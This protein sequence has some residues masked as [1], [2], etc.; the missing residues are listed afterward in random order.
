M[1][2]VGVAFVAGPALE[3]LGALLAGPLQL[4]ARPLS[5]PE[6]G[7]TGSA[8]RAGRNELWLLAGA[9]DAPLATLYAGRAP[10]LGMA[11]RAPAASA[12]AG[13]V[14]PTLAALGPISLV[15]PAETFGALVGVFPGERPS[16][17]PRHDI[18]Q[19]IDHV[20]VSSTDSAATAARFA[21]LFDVPV[22]R[23][24]ARP[25]TNNHLEFMKPGEVVVEF[26]GPPEP[27]PEPVRAWVWG[28][29]LTVWDMVR[30]VNAIRAAGW[31]TTDPRPAVQPGARIAA[32]KGGTDG[33]P[34]ALIQYNA[35]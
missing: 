20:V 10:A 6:A 23:T 4:P 14:H 31:E 11:W 33:V 16:E 35:L 5:F 34:F 30:T 13:K 12:W 8:F 9:D 26:G 7:A 2:D 24:M 25:G 21:A 28:Y 29:V 1:D 15:D 19:C 22:K 27:K 32:L 18:V 17:P 3:Q